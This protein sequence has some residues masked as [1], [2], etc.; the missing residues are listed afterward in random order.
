MTTSEELLRAIE[1]L[2]PAAREE[3]AALVR[4]RAAPPIGG[5]RDEG[6]PER[7]HIVAALAAIPPKFSHPLSREERLRIIAECAGS[8]SREEAAELLRIGREAFDI[9]DDDW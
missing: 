1:A 6:M 5:S 3:I 9:V 8:F 7:S 4:A 2:A